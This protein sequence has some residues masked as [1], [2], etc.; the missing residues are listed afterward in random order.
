MKLGKKF[1]IT[2]NTNGRRR[3][4]LGKLIGMVAIRKVKSRG[5]GIEKGKCFNQLH[6]GK[7]SVML[8]K[9]K[10]VRSTWNLTGE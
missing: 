9:R 3:F 10:P 6:L 7:I 4:R 8:E 1:Y 5:F 2:A